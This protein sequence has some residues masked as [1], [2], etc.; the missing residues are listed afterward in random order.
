MK[1]YIL[2][3]NDG[4]IEL[5]SFELIGASTKRNQAGK[6]G[7]F[8]SGLKYSIAYM[9]RKGIDF[10]IF[11]GEK[12]IK[13]STKEEKL[14][15]QSFERICINGIPT[16]Y[17]TS[18]G[19]TWK[20]DWFVIREIYCNALDESNCILIKDTENISPSS[21]KTRIYVELTESLEKVSQNWDAYF[22]EDRE[23]LFTA[24]NVYTSYLGTEDIEGKN[25]QKVDVYKG[26][27]GVLYRKGVKVYSNKTGIYDYGCESV[28]INEDRTAKHTSA[29]SYLIYSL[30]ARFCNE[31]Y[32]KTVL[33]SEDDRTNEYFSLSNGDRLLGFSDEWIRFSKENLLV[34]R[35]SSG[36]Y[37][38]EIMSSK[39]E[40]F[41][42]PSIF[43]RDLKKSVPATAILGMGSI[44]DGVSI[45]EI[46]TTAKMDYLL[47]N[48][49]NDLKEM[50]YE[51]P[52]D[53]V[54]AEFDDENI[55]GHANIKEKKIIIADRTFNMG[56]REIA[57]T[58]M[59]E[60]EHIKSGHPDETRA[61]QTH[62]FSQWLKMIEDSNAIFL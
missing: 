32:I 27:E 26:T 3:Q 47:K 9:M 13:F 59:E 46:P 42:I 58:L 11:S 36:K 22:S 40:V 48:V 21:G 29:M 56:K 44:I 24:E 41:L 14:R 20:E 2:I 38:A 17:T 37:A 45:N 12:E 4:E 43:A 8:G 53:V 25:V 51:V 33:R 62:I 54:V 55:L 34:V 39:K 52:F 57:M 49:L 61:F 19:P 1:K 6:I 60:T 35:E 18:M 23:P 7:F 30:C 16:S 28:S 31:D 15:D 5:N 50:N 10:K